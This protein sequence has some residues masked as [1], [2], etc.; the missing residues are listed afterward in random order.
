MFKQLIEGLH[1]SKIDGLGRSFTRLGWIGFWLQVVLGSVPL[2]LM[3]YVFVFSGNF[4]GP[5]NG[6]PVVEFLSLANLLVL[7]FTIVWFFRYTA[8]GRR[9]SDPSA[10][11]TESGV[12]NTVWTGL[13]ASSLG[14]LFSM[15]VM[16]LEV[17]QLLF[18]FLS[19]PQAGVPAIQTT[20]A[21]TASW[22]SAVDLLSLMALLLMLAAEVIALV[23]GLWL[24]FR[25]SQCA[26]EFPKT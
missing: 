25:T 12:L 19:A 6:L 8:L 26:A 21:A 18:Y 23:L 14:I 15:I 7:L 4:S 3:L 10:R 11:P 17:G 13:V 9:I 24:I 20:A 16:I 5:R 1:G 22:V 2:V